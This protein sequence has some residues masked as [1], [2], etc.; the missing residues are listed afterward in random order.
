MVRDPLQPRL[1]ALLTWQDGSLAVD[2][3]FGS[4]N[5]AYAGQPVAV[6]VYVSPVKLHC[7]L[8]PPPLGQTVAA[9]RVR[10][11]VNRRAPER[12][13]VHVLSILVP[14]AAR[15]WGQPGRNAIAWAVSTR[16]ST[17]RLRGG[18]ET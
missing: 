9:A 18:T 13:P 8:M 17:R 7:V 4:E 5:S 15:P 11:T 6:T 2:C 10:K 16:R 12:E 3:T 1:H 14:E